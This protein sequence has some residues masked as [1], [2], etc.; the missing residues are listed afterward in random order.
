VR[1][2]EKAAASLMLRSL[3]LVVRHEFR[4][5]VSPLGLSCCPAMQEPLSIE[6]ISWQAMLAKG[7]RE[8]TED[9]IAVLEGEHGPF[10][11]ADGEG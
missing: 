8:A 1:L 5:V 11:L 10:Q 4:V 9:E 3:A 6:D 2:A 7:E